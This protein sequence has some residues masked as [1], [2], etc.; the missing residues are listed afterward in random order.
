[1]Q[2]R[3]LKYLTVT[4]TCL[5]LSLSPV[6]SGADPNLPDESFAQSV[7]PNDPFPHQSTLAPRV[8]FWRHVFGIWS[9]RQAAL[10]DMADPGLVYEV[11]TVPGSGEDGKAFVRDHVED[12]VF[13]LRTLERKVGEGE[14]LTSDEQD[15]FNKFRKIG[16]VSELPG[17]HERVR[18]QRGV[19]EKFLQGVEI[20]GRYD[21][22]FRQIFR[23][24][25]VPEDLAFLPHVESSFQV[26]AR[27]GVGAV[28]IFQFTLSAARTFMTVN[29]A[30]DER[31]DPVLAAEGC[32]RYLAHAY[33]KLGDWGLAIT[34]Y[35]HGIGGMSRAASEFGTDFGRI[36]DRYEGPLFGF[37]SRNFYVEF[38][39]AREVASHA[40]SYFD[41]VHRDAPL[42]WEKVELAYSA[43]IHKVAQYYGVSVSDLT[44]MNAGLTSRAMQGRVSIPE[45]TRIWLPSG[46]QQRVASRAAEP[47]PF[48]T[49]IPDTS[50]DFR[51][52]Q[53]PEPSP[54]PSTYDGAMAQVESP[55][56]V[57]EN[58][59]MHIAPKTTS[60]RLP[61][62]RDYSQDSQD[63]EDSSRQSDEE[64]SAADRSSS[65]RS[66]RAYAHVSTANKPKIFEVRNSTSVVRIHM[67]ELK[68]EKVA[69][70]KTVQ[71]KPVAKPTLVASKAPV[72]KVAKKTTA[73][74]SVVAKAAAKPIVVAS[75][76]KSTTGSSKHSVAV[77]KVTAPAKGIQTKGTHEKP[78]P[79]TRIAQAP[80]QAAKPSKGAASPVKTASAKVSTSAKGNS[81]QAKA[82]SKPT[83]VRTS[84]PVKGSGKKPG[85][86]L[87]KASLVSS[88]REG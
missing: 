88:G 28:G 70:A 24:H 75:A 63:S 46:A 87:V 73:A 19:R 10:H 30:I 43:P 78:S 37:D 61:V 65:G 59:E 18:V 50:S 38:L 22:A 82:G 79:T 84:T 64:S 76:P 45:G 56:R 14:D 20:S 42:D 81:L 52:Y 34:S 72:P 9:R 39:A 51:A 53:P 27:S 83:T 49:Q 41:Q 33:E 66:R 60:R 15:L 2:K 85:A 54:Y 47:A 31:Y 23:A 25:G 86:K 7:S 11:L 67:P 68:P 80:A 40:E 16:K 5:L 13:R 62:L 21:A 69:E 17:A 44:G 57:D 77:S 35:N 32:A 3:Y 6:F 12:L 55:L 74:K 48:E 1:M 29:S 26:S 71:K 58:G 4:S 36:L 8:N